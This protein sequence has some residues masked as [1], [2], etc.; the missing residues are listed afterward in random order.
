LFAALRRAL[1]LLVVIAALLLVAPSAYAKIRTPGGGDV[2]FYARIERGETL[3][4]DEWM[5]IIFYRPQEC[6]PENFNLLDFF[7]LA[8]FSC[9]PPTPDGFTIWA[10]EP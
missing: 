6:V 5:A 2:P 9:T 7:D 4:T 3:H 8:A 1:L 10:G